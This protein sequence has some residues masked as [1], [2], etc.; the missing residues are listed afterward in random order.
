MKDETVD[1]RAHALPFI[2]GGEIPEHRDRSVAEDE[3]TFLAIV[4]LFL[5]SWPFIRPQVM[6]NW[7]RP[8]QGVEQ[9]VAED[10]GG[11]DYHFFY[12]P[13]LLLVV[14]FAG[15]MLGMM[16][17]TADLQWQHYTL[18]GLITVVIAGFSYLTYIP[19]RYQFQSA[20]LLVFLVFA[21]NF[22]ATVVIDGYLD[23][24]YMAAITLACLMGW[25]VQFRTRAAQV[26]SPAYR[27]RVG[28]HL[29]YYYGIEFIRSFIAV[30]I[31]L[32][33]ADMINMSIL[34]ADPLTPKIAALVGIPE[35][36]SDQAGQLS[37]DLRYDIQF[38]Y[39]T[40]SLSLYFIQLPFNL[41]QPWYRMWILQ[42]INQNLRLGL[43]ERWLKLSLQ[44]HSDHRVGDSIFRIYQDSSQVTGVIERLME[45]SRTLFSY[46]VAVVFVSLLSPWLGLIGGTI[47]IPG[48]LWAAW[49]MPRMRTA[50]LVYREATSDLTS[51]IQE[52]FSA[53]RLIKAYGK[54]SKVQTTFEEDAV[55]SFNAAYRVRRLVAL[56]TIVMFTITSVFLLGGEFLIAWWANQG[57]ETF[58]SELI[59]LIGLSFVVWNL[60]AFNWSKGELLASTNTM[61]GLMRQ[62]LT[63]QDMAMGLQRVFDILD[64]EPGVQDTVD[65]VPF[66]SVEDAIRFNNVHF[67]YDGSRRIL[68]GVNLEAKPGS[69]TAIV[70]PTG[71]GKSTLLSLLLRLFDPDEGSITIDD[72]DLKDFQIDTLRA[73]IAIALQENVLFAL[74]VKDNIRYVAPNAS[75]DE[76]VEAIR[77]SCMTDYVDSLPMGIDTEL[78]DRGGR[79]STGQR[80]RLSIA[81]AVVRDTAI[82]ILDEPTAAL[83]AATEHE[84]MNN[85]AE[86]G[87]RRAIFLIT[88]RISTIRQAD[89]ILYLEQGQVLESGDHAALMNIPDGKYRAF[90]ETEAELVNNPGGQS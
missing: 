6:G 61:R 12:A 79:L 67:S 9:S 29:I 25:M 75:D 5:R 31:G 38:R 90:V 17:A 80:Q 72:R 13:I 55:V 60:T 62:W 15:P 21:A 43:Q 4:T 49:A 45:V 36:S 86:W 22:E 83:D 40:I 88:H 66:E 82:L 74:S 59:A 18:Y 34:Q 26:D 89:R 56:V 39:I 41:F 14:A 73:N 71:S 32:L 16:P 30:F 20:L 78:G 2:G 42:R 70:G 3:H 76:V 63:A 35:A 69:I 54:E 77:I 68:Q 24:F 48:L 51:R 46:I 11:G 50:S 8:G 19:G 52:T 64:I 81:R 44:Y 87:Q 37:K 58:A 53:I 23:G 47:V 27:I 1:A 10:I 33:L 84:V 7:W 57:L 28:A 85:L 65:A